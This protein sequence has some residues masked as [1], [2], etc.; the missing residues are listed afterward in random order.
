[1]LLLT[2]DRNKRGRKLPF[3]YFTFFHMLIAFRIKALMVAYLNSI[4]ADLKCS[5][6]SHR[7]GS[8]VQTKLI[9]LIHPQART[10]ATSA[11]EYGEYI[12]QWLKLTKVEGHYLC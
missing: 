7:I 8:A 1:M 3:I 12:G 4:L 5:K 9:A 10:K 11:H 6:C 2:E